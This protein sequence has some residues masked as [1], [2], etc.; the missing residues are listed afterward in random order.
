V[1][2]FDQFFFQLQVVL[3]DAV[4]HHRDVTYPVGMSIGLGR[5]PVGSPAGVADAH[6]TR[7]G[8]L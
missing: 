2:R 8:V 6:L 7:Q 4:M 1:A 5:P 3:D